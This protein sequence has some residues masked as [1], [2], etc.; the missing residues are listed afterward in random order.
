[1][2]SLIS[3]ES[4]ISDP[5]GTCSECPEATTPVPVCDIDEMMS[6]CLKVENGIC[7]FE[8]VHIEL[9]H[10]SCSCVS[11]NP[12]VHYAQPPKDD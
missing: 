5:C 3:N 11:A 1:M 4:L 12:P 7:K 9:C 8:V 6:D 10:V 2:L